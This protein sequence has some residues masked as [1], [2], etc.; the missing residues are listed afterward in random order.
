MVSVN[1]RRFRLP[2][3]KCGQV[4]KLNHAPFSL[5]SHR[6]LGIVTQLIESLIYAIKIKLK[7]T[8]QTYGYIIS[9]LANIINVKTASNFYIKCFF[10]LHDTLH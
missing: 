3:S 5:S 6:R 4:M 8:C 7:I 9:I 2:Q 1:L 10:M